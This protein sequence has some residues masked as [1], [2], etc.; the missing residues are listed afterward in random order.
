MKL[1]VLCVSLL[2]AG[3]WAQ[4]PGFGPSQNLSPEKNFERADAHKDKFLDFVEFLHVDYPFLF[5]RTKT[6]FDLLDTDKNGKVTFE[7]AKANEDKMDADRLTRNEPASARF[8][9]GFDSS[10]NNFL[11]LD[12]LKNFLE[13]EMR[14]KADNLA[15][16]VKAF[17]KNNDGKLDPTGTGIRVKTQ[18]NL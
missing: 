7:E 1:T 14:T 2:F 17:D 9:K 4:D 15:E 11:E 18:N 3:T 10:H 8:F 5:N 16:V 12:E 6:Q 13:T